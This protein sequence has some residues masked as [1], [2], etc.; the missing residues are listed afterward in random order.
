LKP[1]EIFISGGLQ[2]EW[3]VEAAPMIVE[4]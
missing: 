1:S 3:H 4:R 2:G